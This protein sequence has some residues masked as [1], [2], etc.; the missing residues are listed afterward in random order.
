MGG[1]TRRW[2]AT[3]AAMAAALALGAC[4]EGPGG[5]GGGGGEGV[6][7]APAKA[8]KMPDSPVTLNVLDVAGNLQLTKGAIEKYKEE[9]P[10]AARRV[11]FTTATAPELPG[12][13][14]GPA[15]RGPARHRPRADRHRRPRRRA[16]RRGCG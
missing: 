5:G 6:E 13:G 7:T 8:P 16:S 10:K 4:G 1:R 12:Q 3:V 11:T 9:N 2:A 15:E 14:Q